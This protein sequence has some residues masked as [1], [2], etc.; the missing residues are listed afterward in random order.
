MF[1]F[2]GHR[3][4]DCHCE[5]ADCLKINRSNSF[6]HFLFQEYSDD[7]PAATAAVFTIVPIMIFFV[8]A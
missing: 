2:D 1:H 7:S 3:H 8:A 6:G 4:T 5:K